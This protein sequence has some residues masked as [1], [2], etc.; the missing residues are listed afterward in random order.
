MV[1]SDAELSEVE[2]V[3][4]VGEILAFPAKQKIRLV[5][6]PKGTS[7]NK[8]HKATGRT[9]EHLEASEVELLLEAAKQ[10]ERNGWRNYCLILTM[11]RHALRVGEA[12]DLRWTD[13]NFGDGRIFVRRSKGSNDSTHF[14]EGDEIRA[15][16]RLQRE[17]PSS[18][19]IF[20]ASGGSPLATSAIASMIKRI[21]KAVL[22]FPVHSHM[23][24]H[25]CGH[26]LAMKGTDTRTIQ[27]Y[28]GHVCIRHTVR[29]TALSPSKFRGLWS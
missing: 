5:P 27:D 10:Q 23:L 4:D 12:A 8:G 24:R 25:S 17:S 2:Q 6:Q 9:R 3:S 20:L 15:L 11:Y 7:P 29:Y 22:P 16:K 14:L 19:Y 26:Y 18:P 1:F 21:G 28:L 13:I